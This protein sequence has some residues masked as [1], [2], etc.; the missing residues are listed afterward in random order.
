MAQVRIEVG[1]QANASVSRAFVPLGE[2][3]ERAKNVAS[4]AMAGMW[5]AIAR[6]GD[7]A[8]R[9]FAKT[10]AEMQR[11]VAKGT[12]DREKL[13][14]KS[15]E[16]RTRE[17]LRDFDRRLRETRRRREAEE[18]GGAGPGRDSRGRFLPGAGSRPDSAGGTKD[19][20]RAVVDTARNAASN[21][22]GALRFGAGVAGD[23]ARGAGVNF[24]LS[25]LVGRR[26]ALDKRARDL[27]NSAWVQSGDE[28][29]KVMRDPRELMALAQQVGDKTAT[30]YEK[31]L[32]GLQEFVGK[33]GDLK[34]GELALERLAKLSRAT[35]AELDDMVSAA[36]AVANALGDMGSK[37]EKA[38]AIDELMRSLAGQG[39]LG[40]VEIKDLASQFDKL[41]AAAGKFKFEGESDKDSRVRSLKTMGVLAQIARATGGAWNA[42]V[43]TNAVSGMVNTLSTP[44]RIKAFK[45]QGIDPYKGGFLQDPISLIKASLVASK[46]NRE[47][48]KKMWMNVMGERA[49]GGFMQ[50]FL[51]AG[52]ASGDQEKVTKALDKIDEQFKDIFKAEMTKGEVDKQFNRS[53]E[54]PE[55]KAQLFQNQLE[56]IAGAMADKVLPNLERLGPQILKAV[57]A[58]ASVTAW[59]AENPGSAITLAIVGSIAKAA[60]GT[61]VGAAIT[62]AIAGGAGAAIL[63]KLAAAALP[64]GAAIAVGAATF[65]IT[66]A[67]IEWASEETSKGVNTSVDNDARTMN[68]LLAAKGNLRGEGTQ[69]AQTTL[70]QLQEAQASLEQR[71][72]AA[73]DP[74]GVLGAI[75]TDKTLQDRASEQNDARN[76]STLKEDLQQVVSAIKALQ[77]TVAAGIPVSNLPE[78]GFSIP[79]VDMKG[80]TE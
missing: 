30:D 67:I 57:E 79:T 9:Q 72:T 29:Q 10:F 15:A 33:T 59:A 65:F 52:G 21:I 62:S 46:G 44:A 69:D 5:R 43:A 74:T 77:G 37:A 6:G 75:F 73:Q 71:I 23:F 13:E 58:F 28:D 19:T 22:G 76:I 38:D 1:A 50:T 48:F 18:R 42:N 26:V 27:A 35:G 32:A 25:S 63:T 64:A 61:A 70:A 41:G 11:I 80:R 36:G 45:A 12:A 66:K 68:A 20:R 56:K 2:A 17:E 53:M 55:A 24:D 14:A 39:K 60:I 31:A 16:R 3:A 4:N 7:Q 49:V 47:E 8:V 54:G 51:D 40:A 78:G 34:T